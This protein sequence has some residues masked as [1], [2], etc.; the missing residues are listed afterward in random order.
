M[1]NYDRI[2]VSEGIYVNKI[3]SLSKDCII[4]HYWYFLGFNHLSVMAAMMYWWFSFHYS[5]YPNNVNNVYADKI[6]IYN[7]VSCDK[8]GFKYFIGFK[9]DEKVKSLCILLPQMSGYAK[10]LYETKYVFHDNS[11]LLEKH[12]IRWDKVNNNIW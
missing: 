1:I 3:L 11:K 10:I 2:D 12:N 9:D 5:K 8:K 6:I 4:C 7:K